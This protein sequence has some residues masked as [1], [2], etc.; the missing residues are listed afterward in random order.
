MPPTAQVLILELKKLG[1]GL[2]ADRDLQASQGEVPISSPPY[3][4]YGV[5]KNGSWP[6]ITPGLRLPWEASPH[7]PSP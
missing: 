3:F 7:V 6:R 2:F 1:H 5:L 4:S